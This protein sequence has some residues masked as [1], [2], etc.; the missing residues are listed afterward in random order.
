MTWANKVGFSLIA[1]IIVFTTIAYGT[2]H[3]S[4]L[5]VFYVLIALGTL[6]WAIDG[7]FSGSVRIS[8]EPIQLALLAAAGYGFVQ[9]IPFGWLAQTGGIEQVPRTISLDPFATRVS[10]MHF[11]ALL[12]FFGFALVLVDSA[13]RIRRLA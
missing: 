12:L 11:I 13:S 8:R 6:L 1:A 3:Q 5:S 4:V 9:I 10:A 7:F 2:V